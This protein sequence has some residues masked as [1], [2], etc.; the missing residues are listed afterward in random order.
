M[1]LWLPSWLQL[2]RDG[3]CQWLLLGTSRLQWRRLANKVSC[4]VQWMMLRDSYARRTSCVTTS[5][6]RQSIIMFVWSSGRVS[7]LTL[8]EKSTTFSANASIPTLKKGTRVREGQPKRLP[9]EPPLS[10]TILCLPMF[11]ACGNLLNFVKSKTKPCPLV[12][13]RWTGKLL[14]FVL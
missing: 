9:M 12:N 8:V 11:S 7:Y 6:G 1:Q 14:P 4:W 3:M 2:V 13:V 10:S 5:E